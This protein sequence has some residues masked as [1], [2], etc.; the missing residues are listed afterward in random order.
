MASD[1][2]DIKEWT[3]IFGGLANQ[4]RLKILQLLHKNQSLSVTELAEELGISFKN[5]SRNLRILTGLNL[6]EFE[7]KKDRVYYSL[8]SKLLPEVKKVLD[9]S[10]IR[11]F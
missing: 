1:K 10:G 7:G 6:V 2:K 5:T 3:T 4:N 8:S 9:A 11:S